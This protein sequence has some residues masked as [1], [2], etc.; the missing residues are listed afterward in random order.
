MNLKLSED[1]RFLEIEKVDNINEF[2]Q[3]RHSLTRKVKNYRFIP[4]VKQG[5]WDGSVSFYD[6]KDR[7]PSG[8]WKYCYDALKEFGYSCN[9]S[10]IENLFDPNLDKDDFYEFVED[11]YKRDKIKPRDYQVDAA[12]RI[13]KYRRTASLMSTS[14]GKTLVIYTVLAYALAKGLIKNM[15]MI[16]PNV[17][18]VIQATNDF[19]EYNRHHDKKVKVQQVYH[20]REESYGTNVTIGTY[21]SLVKLDK[22]Y[23]KKFDAVVVDELHKAKANSITKIM[24]NLWHCN[25]RFGVTGTLPSEKTAE[26]LTI[27][28]QTG[29]I[30]NRVGADE[31]IQDG[32]ITPVKITV[33]RL[34]YKDQSIKESFYELSKRLDSTKL[35]QEEKKFITSYAPRLN[36]LSNLI[37]KGKYNTLVLFHLIEHGK[38][39]YEKILSIKGENVFYVDGNTKA[40]DREDYKKY[41]EQGHGRILVASYGTFSTGISINNIHNIFLTESFKSDI[42]IKQSIGRGLRKH[43]SKDILNVVDVVDDL[44]YVTEHGFEYVN[45]TMK[46]GKERMR[47]YKKEKFPFVIKEINL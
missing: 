12:Y 32:Y 35:F 39:L 20:G 14:S 45:Y 29:P 1:K 2:D 16:V 36:F 22:N 10:N 47:I 3:L 30:V 27:V 34:K 33:L 43:G 24:G 26:Y 13:L 5:L 19:Y 15:L 9:I 37:S 42:L 40:K 6:S 41:M 7:I 8:L 18:L 28:S 23:F 21:Q 44:S 38:A 4:S 25:Y 46:H 31:L 17:S 11:L